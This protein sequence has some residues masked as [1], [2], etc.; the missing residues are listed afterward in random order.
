MPVIT[1]A[2]GLFS[3]AANI[4]SNFLGNTTVKDLLNAGIDYAT[5]EKIASDLQKQAG[6]I[7][8]QAVAAGRAAQVP[9]TPY[10][11]TTGMGTT[12]IGPTG[13]TME[14]TPEYQQLQRE[15]L[16]RSQS[17][18]GAINP[19]QTAQTLFQQAE[20]LAAPG[21]AREQE[22]LL[23]GLQ[24]RGL[25]G[26]GQNLPTVGGG[27]RTVNPLFESL[28]SA[29]ET[30][31]A[32]LALQAQQGGTAEALRQQQLAAGLQTQAQNV[33]VQQLNQLLRAQGLSQDQINLAVKNAEAQRASTIAGLQYSTPLLLN[34]AG[35]R[36]GQT[37]NIAQGAQNLIGNIFSSTI[38]SLFTNPANTGGFGSGYIFGNR[39]LGENF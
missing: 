17:A 15:A 22:A 27:V 21:R 24:A 10:T 16:L 5:A 36:A 20:A 35:V 13:A 38:P 2:G 30:A 25:T 14:A 37:A 7:Q 19:A 3:G 26:F 8:G 1:N 12:T 39:D 18:I 32:N 29:Q 33:D 28:L 4:L 31:R 34:A 6:N 23:Q 9:F 11:V